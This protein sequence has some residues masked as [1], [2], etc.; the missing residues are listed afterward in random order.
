M[1]INPEKDETCMGRN[2]EAVRGPPAG[3]ATTVDNYIHAYSDTHK[4]VAM[5]YIQMLARTI[6]MYLARTL[7]G[8]QMAICMDACVK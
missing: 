3:A 2:S 5:A 6:Y 4:L 8:C 1:R 7:Q